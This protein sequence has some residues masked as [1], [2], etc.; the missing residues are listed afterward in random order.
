L[1]LDSQL[2]GLDFS[3][4]VRRNDHLELQSDNF[5]E[6]VATWTTEGDLDLV[7]V[8]TGNSMVVHLERHL[9]L[10]G[11]LATNLKVDWHVDHLDGEVLKSVSG[12]LGQGEDA[13]I[14]PWPVGAVLNLNGWEKD[15][16]WLS[17][18]HVVRDGDWDC[19]DGVPVLVAPVV[20]LVLAL[21]L[22]LEL[23]ELAFDVFDVEAHL[24]HKLAHHLFHAATA[25][26]AA[27]TASA[28]A[29]S[30]THEL[31]WVLHLWLTRLLFA[32]NFRQ[33]GDHDVWVLRLLLDLEEGVAV[34]QALF[35]V[36]AEIEVLA[37]GALVAD[38]DDRVDIAAIASD[39]LVD[40]LA[41]ASSIFTLH[42][43]VSAKLVSNVALTED[44]L[45]DLL[46][47]VLQLHL[48]EGL[49]SLAVHVVS[50]LTATFALAAWK[51]FLLSYLLDLL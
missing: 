17:F 11:G 43:L 36:A 7:H 21:V 38:T 47:L 31:E 19:A 22:V 30:T 51:R 12:F 37:D 1:Q 33:D 48:D 26:A 41:V 2:H 40:D 35:A 18:E 46:G 32:F 5:S 29:T 6:L 9:H 50:T 8:F 23:L 13:S 20:A 24:L 10:E 44:L 15:L 42:L 16:T 34:R 45:E 25:T 3:V 49:E 39:V 4:F 27:A 14:L 28:S